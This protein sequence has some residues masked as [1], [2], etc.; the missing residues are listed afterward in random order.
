MLSSDR[1]E[2]KYLH[3][4]TTLYQSTSG[5]GKEEGESKQM[6]ERREGGKEKREREEGE[7][8]GEREKGKEKGGHPHSQELASL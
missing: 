6:E 4:L 3:C 2:V 1:N 7:R 8:R 5:W